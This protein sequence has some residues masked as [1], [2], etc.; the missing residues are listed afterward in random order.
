MSLT[1]RGAILPAERAP[2]AVHEWQTTPRPDDVVLEVELC[3][4]CGTDLHVWQGE[5]VGSRFP[6]LLGHENVSRIVDAPKGLR[7]VTGRPLGVGDRVVSAS[8]Y[9]GECGRCMQC[10]ELNA[11][12]LCAHRAPSSVHVDGEDVGI[13]GGGFARYLTLSPPESRLLLRTDV[14]PEAAA[15]YEPLTVAVQMVLGGPAVLGADVVVQGTGAI[16][17]LT[18]LLARAM[19]AATIIA[20]GAP[21][22]RLQIA[23]EFGADVTIDIMELADSGDRVAAVRAATLGGIGAS[24]SYEIAGVPA[25]V[26]EGLRY[27]RPSGVLMEAGSAADTGN[28]TINPHLDIQRER[29]EIRGVRGRQLRDFTVAGR[30]LD[31]F[32]PQLTRLLSHRLPLTRVEDGLRAMSGSYSL[33]GVDVLKVAIQP[34]AAG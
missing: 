30:L 15:L 7:D 12:W 33:D 8:A 18:V 9:F 13:F 2:F 24:V 1:N 27:L 21:R 10:A 29:R 22:A 4:M 26:S 5:W 34:G 32:A 19:G 23:K 20:V 16:G 17:L 6:L 14:A 28:V 11:P 31:R 25:A 3:G